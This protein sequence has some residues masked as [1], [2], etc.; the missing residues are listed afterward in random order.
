MLEIGP[1]LAFLIAGSMSV[2][3]KL[4][5]LFIA[6]KIIKLG[7]DLLLR[8]VRGEFKFAGE[9]QG[10][11]ADLRSASPGLL[12]LLLGCIVI[13]IAVT[14]KYTHTLKDSN[15]S[16]SQ[17]DDKNASNVVPLRL[18]PLGQQDEELSKF[19]GED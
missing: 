13:I 1:K 9:I 11:K 4:V 7:Y 19:L 10:N 5:T 16:M 8:G 17:F 15:E 3:F 6:Y 2:I 12:F 18:P 14:T